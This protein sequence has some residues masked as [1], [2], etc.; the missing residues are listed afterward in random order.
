MAR[1]EVIAQTEALRSCGGMLKISGPEA[2]HL[3][4]ARRVRT[5]ASVR[6]KD[7]MGLMF[8]ARVA[9]VSGDGVSLELIEELPCPD[10]T[11]PLILMPAVIKGN[12]MDWLI[13]KACELGVRE[14]RPVITSRTVAGSAGDSGRCRRWRSI[15]MQALKQCSG[16]RLTRIHVPAGL[17]E[18]VDNS[19]AEFKIILC[20]NTVKKSLISLFTE[21]VPG[22]SAC[23]LTGPEGGFSRDEINLCNRAGFAQA[24]LGTRILRTETAAVTAAAQF[25]GAITGPEAGG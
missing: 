25:M 16:N 17:P 24:T 5:G 15:A 14:I 9:A 20:E 2:R 12:R 8:A 21:M 19:G 18:L 6:I 3:A 7:G 1:Y 4:R 23:I 10:D 11:L 22:Q 13:Q